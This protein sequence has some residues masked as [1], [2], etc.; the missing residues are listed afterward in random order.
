MTKKMRAKVIRKTKMEKIIE[1]EVKERT[2]LE[3]L[4]FVQMVFDFYAAPV[5]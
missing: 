3:K 5:G 1:K 2:F 4:G